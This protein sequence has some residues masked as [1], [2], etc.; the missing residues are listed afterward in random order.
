MAGEKQ[1]WPKALANAVNLATSVAMSVAI[2]ILGG[3]W[4]DDKFNTDI[5]FT[6]LGSVLGLATAGKIMWDRLNE[7]GSS[8]Q[9]NDNDS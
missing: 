8:S 3:I 6:I 5:L 4:L 9:S 7:S 1:N 2:G